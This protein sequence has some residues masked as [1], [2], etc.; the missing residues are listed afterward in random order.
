HIFAALAEFERDILRQR[1]NAGLKKGMAADL[2]LLGDLDLGVLA[3][4]QQRTR[5]LEIR[6]TKCFGSP[7]HTSPPACGFGAPCRR[8]RPN[9]PADAFG[10][11]EKYASLLCHATFAD[12]VR[13]MGAGCRMGSD[14]LA[15]QGDAESL[16]NGGTG[17]GGSGKTHPG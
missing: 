12:P 1:V 5:L 2:K 11:V 16:S 8:R 13:R 4:T 6:F 14:R 15:W 9:D 3:G 17:P 7:T 10:P